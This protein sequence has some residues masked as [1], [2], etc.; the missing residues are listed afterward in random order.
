MRDIRSEV[1]SMNAFKT[2]AKS[3]SLK[4]MICLFHFQKI[5]K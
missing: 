5:E 4:L 3:I 2:L 1:K